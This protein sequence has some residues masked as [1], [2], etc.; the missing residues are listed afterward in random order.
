M[1][2]RKAR[3]QDTSAIVEVIAPFVDAVTTT[4]QGRLHFKAEAIQTIFERTDI[5]YYV[6]E[7]DCKVVGVVAYM[8]PAHFMHFFL[9]KAY[10]GQGFG[11]QMWHFL[12]H[13]I[14]RHGHCSI[15]VKS[16][17]YARD[18]YKQFGFVE[19]G[20]YTEEYGI[21]FIPMRKGYPDC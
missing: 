1:K 10:Q 20:N 2:I 11:R 5:H 17:I 18:I 7:I 6:A 16:S 19:T 4:E 3:I 12:E 21:R 8:E 13:E 15:T 14:R 9:N